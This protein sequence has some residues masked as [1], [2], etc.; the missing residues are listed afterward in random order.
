M[1]PRNLLQRLMPGK[2]IRDGGREHV[3]LSPFL[4][5]DDRNVAVGRTHISYDTVIMFYKDRV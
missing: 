4:P 5:H 1:H 2:M 3:N